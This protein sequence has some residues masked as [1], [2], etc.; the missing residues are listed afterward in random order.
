ML[1]REIADRVFEEYEGFP[2]PVV[3]F[4]GWEYNVPGN[5]WKRMC[6][7]ENSNDPDGDT[8]PVWFTVTF[9][10]MESKEVSYCSHHFA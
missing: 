10:D 2:S 1:R 3:E 9:A 4:N 8:I 5:Y 6:F 7:L